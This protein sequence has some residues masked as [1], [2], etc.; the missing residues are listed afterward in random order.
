MKTFVLA[1]L[2][3]FYATVVSAAGWTTPDEVAEHETFRHQAPCADT[4]SGEW[5]TCFL[6]GNEGNFYLVFVQ[7]GEPVFM[8]HVVPPT[9]YQ[10]IWRADT[11]L[12]TSL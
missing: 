5:G 12:G 2:F 3:V 9:P 11:P 7:N 4:E 8:R 6:F 1:T 10:T